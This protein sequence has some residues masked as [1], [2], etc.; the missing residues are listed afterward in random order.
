MKK[1]I[2]GIIMSCVAFFAGCDWLNSTVNNPNAEKYAT[3]VG[4]AVA[5][6]VKTS[7]KLLSDK[8][9][10]N[11]FVVSLDEVIAKLP[12]DVSTSNVVNHI[13]TIAQSKIVEGVTDESKKKMYSTV[14]STVYPLIGKGLE[15]VVS[16]YADEFATAEKTYGIV[17]AFLNSARAQ[18]ND[19]LAA[20]STNDKEFNEILIE[21]QKKLGATIRSPISIKNIVSPT[22]NK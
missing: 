18:F 8:D 12:K 15:L 21:V 17:V 5:I 11:K 6:V 4:K 9:I 13:Q 3:N 20:T 19:I 22:T 1:I 16:K 10:K 2:F 7:D 14:V